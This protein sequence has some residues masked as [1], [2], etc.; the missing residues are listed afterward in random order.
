M[1]RLTCCVCGELA[2]ALHQWWNRDTG[3]G[4]CGRCAAW[5]KTRPD[6]DPAEFRSCYG[7]EG[8]HWMPEPADVEPWPGSG[9]TAPS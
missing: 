9:T 5:L 4:L 8:V 1:L 3:Y 2:R 7:D 6:Y